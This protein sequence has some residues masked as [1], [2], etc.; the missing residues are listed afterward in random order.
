MSTLVHQQPEGEGGTKGKEAFV[1]HLG[2]FPVC[3]RKQRAH[4]CLEKLN[5]LL[6]SS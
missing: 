4:A 2:E 3:Q 6:S 1:I 5:T